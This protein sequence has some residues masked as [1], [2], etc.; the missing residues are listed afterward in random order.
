MQTRFRKGNAV[1]KLILEARVGGK[2]HVLDLG[3]C[4]LVIG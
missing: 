3:E 2:I 4:R 1:G